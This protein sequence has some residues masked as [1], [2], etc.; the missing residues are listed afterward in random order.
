MSKNELTSPYS[1]R[2]ITTLLKPM[3]LGNM[4]LVDS[5]KKSDRKIHGQKQAAEPKRQ[6]ISDCKRCVLSH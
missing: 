3:E 6:K 1:I 2:D 5:I 4:M